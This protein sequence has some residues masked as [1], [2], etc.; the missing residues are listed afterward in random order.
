MSN[1]VPLFLGE[2]ALRLEDMTWRRG[3]HVSWDRGGEN[4]CIEVK[5]TCLRCGSLVYLEFG[6]GPV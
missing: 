5:G 6:L 2:R 1:V 3:L 4:S